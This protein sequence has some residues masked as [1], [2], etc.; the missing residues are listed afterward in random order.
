MPFRRTMGEV[1]LHDVDAA[2]RALESDHHLAI[3]AAVHTELDRAHTV[4]GRNIVENLR[5]KFGHF[6]E[7]PIAGRIPVKRDE[8]LDALEALRPVGDGRL[9]ESGSSHEE[10][11]KR[12]TYPK[13]GVP[14][15]EWC[16]IVP[17]IGSRGWYKAPGGG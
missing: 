4:S 6:E 1:L 7:N 11:G 12:N 3:D 10:P 17:Q 2:S 9:G 16:Q 15:D 5:S 14:P 13:H 8:S